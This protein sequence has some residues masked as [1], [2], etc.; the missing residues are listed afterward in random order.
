VPPETVRY[1]RLLE[2]WSA[3]GFALLLLGTIALLQLTDIRPWVAVLIS[4]TFYLVLESAFRRRLGPLV[5]NVTRLL[6]VIGALILIWEFMG[7]LLILALVGIAAL[8]I[9]DNVGEL[10]R[11]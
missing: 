7:A 3:I 8:T 10:R 4:V 5:I 1:G 9:A 6:A 2:F 11:R